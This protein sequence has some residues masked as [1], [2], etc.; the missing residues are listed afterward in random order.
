MN[1]LLIFERIRYSGLQIGQLH[2]RFIATTQKT[3]RA[4]LV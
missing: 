4:N 2:F 1:V 3:R